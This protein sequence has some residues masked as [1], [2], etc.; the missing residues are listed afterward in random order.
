[1]IAVI[2]SKYGCCWG[3]LPFHLWIITVKSLPPGCCQH[4]R[5]GIAAPGCSAWERMARDRV[6][7]LDPLSAVVAAASNTFQMLPHC[8]F[9]AQWVQ[10]RFCKAWNADVLCKPDLRFAFL[11]HTK[12]LLFD[13]NFQL[14]GH[15]KLWVQ[16]LDMHMNPDS[17]KTFPEKRSTLPDQGSRFGERGLKSPITWPRSSESVL[18]AT[19]PCTNAFLPG[20]LIDWLIDWAT[21][22]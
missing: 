18:L 11:G 3:E 4:Q 2:S 16:Q 22:Y 21:V 14:P 13:V 9:A 6:L 8:T 7:L 20:W 10:C 19:R 12:P 5:A 15:T 17:L 1:M